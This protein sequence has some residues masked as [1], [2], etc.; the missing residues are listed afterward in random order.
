M[1]LAHIGDEPQLFSQ[2]VLGRDVAVIVV[3]CAPQT[4]D[5]TDRP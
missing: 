4:A 5:L 3:E 1:G 2:Y